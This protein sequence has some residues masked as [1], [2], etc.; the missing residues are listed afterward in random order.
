MSLPFDPIAEACK[1]WEKHGWTAVEQMAVA[2]SV[3]RAHQIL[4]QHIDNSLN[5]FGLNF[6]RF[7]ALALLYSTRKGSLP[8]GKIGNR[9]QVHPTSVTNTIDRLENDGLVVRKPH[10][11]D[12]RATLAEITEEGR[13]RVSLAAKSLGEIEYGLKAMSEKDLKKIKTGLSSLRHSEGDF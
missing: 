13:S 12:K 2:T 6:S 7:E 3:T 1:N 8:L 10:P 4:L 5:S 9:L 11:S